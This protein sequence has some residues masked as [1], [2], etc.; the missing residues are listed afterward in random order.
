MAT[1][2]SH[3]CN[4]REGHDGALISLKF[5]GRSNRV[6]RARAAVVPPSGGLP[7]APVG[8]GDQTQE[9]GRHG[10]RF[11]RR[12]EILADAHGVRR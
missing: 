6:E 3:A 8:P 2:R 1:H 12:C 4:V 5:P 10:P 7:L 11:S 9:L